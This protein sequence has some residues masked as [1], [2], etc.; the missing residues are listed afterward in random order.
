MGQRPLKPPTDYKRNWELLTDLRAECVGV[1]QL[2]HY[3]PLK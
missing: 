3:T 1:K 2:G